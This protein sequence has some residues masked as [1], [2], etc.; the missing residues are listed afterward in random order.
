MK[1]KAEEVV[2]PRPGPAPWGL[3]LE[4]AVI[5][6]GALLLFFRP[7]TGDSV[8]AW[9]RLMLLAGP[10]FA[11]LLTLERRLSR[12]IRSRTV[13]TYPTTIP[14]VLVLAGLSIFLVGAVNRALPSRSRWVHPHL[15]GW[16]PVEF[17]NGKPIRDPIPKAHTTVWLAVVDSWKEG[18]GTLQLPLAGE[19][20]ERIAD[21]PSLEPEVR[22]ADGFLGVE[23]MDAVRLARAP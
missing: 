22:V 17:S 14:I 20:V 9:G 3:F 16:L 2:D 19:D 5:G 13:G 7:L 18:G 6:A 23:Y 4:L 21:D 1:T 11:L 8:L 12:G 10:L 15:Q